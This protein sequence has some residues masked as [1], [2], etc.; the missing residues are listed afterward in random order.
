MIVNVRRGRRTYRRYSQYGSAHSETENTY[1]TLSGRY[2]AV[3]PH[4]SPN[5]PS[6]KISV[7][8]RISNESKLTEVAMVSAGP[9]SRAKHNNESDRK[10]SRSQNEPLVEHDTRYRATIDREGGDLLRI[11]VLLRA[12]EYDECLDCNDLCIS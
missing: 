12:P 1:T 9:D 4:D 8:Y 11:G 10:P 6:I 5:T 7:Q 2:P 3:I